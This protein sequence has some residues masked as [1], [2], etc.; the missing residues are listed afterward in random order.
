VVDHTV[1]AFRS[2][3]LFP[4]VGFVEDEAVLLALQRGLGRLILFQ[5]V[6]V[7]Q[8]QEP[9]CLL[10]IVKFCGTAGRAMS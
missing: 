7:F 3:P 8:E 4:S 10:G 5:P 2:G 6:E 1:L 9:G